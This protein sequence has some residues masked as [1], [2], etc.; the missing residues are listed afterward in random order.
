MPTAPDD[1]DDPLTFDEIERAIRANETRHLPP[2]AQRFF[3]DDYDPDD[4]SGIAYGDNPYDALEP[5]PEFRRLTRGGL[6]L[7]PPESLDDA[8]VTAKLWEVIAAL[9]ER[10]MYLYHT[11]HLSDRELYAELVEEVLWEDLSS[12]PCPGLYKDDSNCW[13]SHV[14]ILGGCSENDA[15]IL[16]K[17]YE[18]DEEDRKLW[19]EWFEPEQVPA[20]RP[21]PYDRDRHLPQPVELE[22]VYEDEW[23]N[24][25]SDG[26]GEG[27]SP[28]DGR[29]E[30]QFRDEDIPF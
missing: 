27:M 8:A 12:N 19:A 18:Q 17:Y 21:P 5:Q 1:P 11:D 16:L 10:H 3:D 25:E 20:W 15:L 23:L 29:D 22:P 9:A 28:D 2:E 14:D 24:R 26:G 7:P 30:H 13:T 4:E 6:S